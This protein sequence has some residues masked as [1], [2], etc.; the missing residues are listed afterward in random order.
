MDT[1]KLKTYR[2]KHSMKNLKQYMIKI[3]DISVYGVLKQYN[4]SLNKSNIHFKI[5][6][7]FISCFK[8]SSITNANIDRVLLRLKHVFLVTEN[9]ILQKKT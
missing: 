2:G 8:Y 3:L 4:F 9:T 7:V 5:Y 6:S 1:R